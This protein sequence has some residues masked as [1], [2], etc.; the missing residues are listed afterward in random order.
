MRPIPTPF[1][2]SAGAVAARLRIHDTGLCLVA[3]HLSS[4]EGDGDEL[5]RNYDYSEIVRRAA[6]PPDSSTSV[7]PEALEAQQQPEGVSK[8]CHIAYCRGSHPS[9]AA[10]GCRAHVPGMGS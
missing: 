9:A 6:F 3:A 7:D 8:A 1:C 4:G 5:R 2:W 10:Q